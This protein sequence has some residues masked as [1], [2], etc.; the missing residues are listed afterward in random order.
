MTFDETL[1]T[2]AAALRRDFD[3]TF[4][5]PIGAQGL[6]DEEL[7]AIRV[8]HDP[9]VIRLTEIAGLFADKHI[10]R[11]P[12]PLSDLLGLAGF[13]GAVV[14]VYDLRL[15]LGCS[16]I[17]RPRWSVLTAGTSCVG[18][19]FDALDGHLR[20][21]RG[22]LASDLAG[23]AANRPVREV[24][25]LGNVARPVIHIPSLVSSIVRRVRPDLPEKEP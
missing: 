18:L 10:T 13:R 1:C 7:L 15:L 3:Q 17:T 12:G 24:A 11:V 23:P 2:R 5:E 8:G 4:A 16:N 21:P 20:L 6:D 22:S 14:P 25:R 19:A 9:F